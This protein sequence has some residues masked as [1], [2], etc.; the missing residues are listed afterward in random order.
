[1]FQVHLQDGVFASLPFALYCFSLPLEIG[2]LRSS[3]VGE[4]FSAFGGSICVFP[5]RKKRQIWSAMARHVRNVSYSPRGHLFYCPRRATLLACNIACTEQKLAV[6][7]WN[8]G[9]CQLDFLFEMT[10]SARVSYFGFLSVLPPTTTSAVPLVLS[11]EWLLSLF[12]RSVYNQSANSW[13]RS[14]ALKQ[15]AYLEVP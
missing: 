14:S 12:P 2:F 7:G 9:V 4:H 5:G 10:W 1:M 8:G 6:F 3:I 11:S 15:N 13:L